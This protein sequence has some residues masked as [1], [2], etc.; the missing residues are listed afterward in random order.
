M[1]RLTAHLRSRGVALRR[2][3]PVRQVVQEK[4]SVYSGRKWPKSAL[5]AVKDQD[6]RVLLHRDETLLP[7]RRKAWSSWVCKADGSDDAARIGVTD[8][9]N[10]LQD[11][12][13]SDPLFVSLNPARGARGA[14]L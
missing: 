10:R 4:N 2:G 9:M 14:G 7:R 8:W 11:I 1:H 3:T 13:E 6:N 5:G 12:T